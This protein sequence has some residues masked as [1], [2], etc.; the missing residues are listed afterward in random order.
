M[1]KNNFLLLGLFF[2]TTTIS[3]QVKVVNLLTENQT[4]PIGL[5]VQQPRFTWQLMSEQR[6]ISQTAYEITVSG[7]K[8]SVWKSGKINSDRSVQVPYA[9]TALQSGKK[10]T[11]QVR[12]WDNNGKASASSEPAFFQTAMMSSVDWKAKWIEAD[13]TEDSINRPALYFRKQF[14]S[15]RKLYQL[16]LTSPRMVCMKH[17]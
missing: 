7:S 16:L 4:N 8:G 14:S 17:K 6:N 15:T 11:W 13:L 5:D 10:Y 9:G 12:I 2:L 1:R 3:A